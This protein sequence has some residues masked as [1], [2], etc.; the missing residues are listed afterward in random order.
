MRIQPVIWLRLLV[1]VRE[2][3]AVP[4]ATPRPCRMPTGSTPDVGFTAAPQ[5]APVPRKVWNGHGAPGGKTGATPQ[6]GRTG[7]GSFRS[8]VR[9]A[10]A[11]LDL[12][13][14]ELK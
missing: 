13:R 12:I 14:Q 3:G 6:S 8:S 4:L 11:E 2:R 5:P 9:V 7:G 1:V 10:R